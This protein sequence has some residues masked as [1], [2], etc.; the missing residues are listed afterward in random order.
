MVMNLGGYF[1]Y[2]G[3][4]NSSNTGR[5]FKIYA[6]F[7]DGSEV[8]VGLISRKDVTAL[9]RGERSRPICKYVEKLPETTTPLKTLDF[10]V[11]LSTQKERQQ[12]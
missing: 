1:V 8:F 11:K 12:L 4:A 5:S 10:S 2:A 6:K 3:H 7:P 9:L